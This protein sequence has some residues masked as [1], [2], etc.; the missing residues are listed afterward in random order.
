MMKKYRSAEDI[1][2]KNKELRESIKNYTF[3]YNKRT[4]RSN[5]FFLMLAFASKAQ[6]ATND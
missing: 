6:E 2:K 5:K 1:R 3:L 4:A